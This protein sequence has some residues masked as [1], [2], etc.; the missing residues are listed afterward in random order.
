M[1]VDRPQQGVSSQ[2]RPALVLSVKR[3]TWRR[4]DPDREA[5]DAAYA[6]VRLDVL[7]RDAYTCKY[8]G[9]VSSGDS[10]ANTGSYA[11]SGYLEVHH[12]DDNH[13]NNQISNLVTVCPFC[14]QVFHVGFAGKRA[15]AQLTWFPWLP[16][17]TVN[18]MSNL[19]A[20]AIAREGAWAQAGHSWFQWMGQLQTQSARVYGDAILDVGNLGMALMSCA[21]QGS[22]GWTNRAQ[23]T[24]ALRLIPRRDVYTQAIQWWSQ[25]AWRP[26]AQWESVFAEAIGLCK[27]L[28]R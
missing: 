2:K 5:A 8:C 22:P 3:S 12:Q 20:V 6:R 26:E 14:H 16:Q 27:D 28:Q 23:A 11:A 25:Q 9:F 13:K 19:A 15:A 4:H 18:L 21:S 7:R 10:Q 17:A 1:A 24:A